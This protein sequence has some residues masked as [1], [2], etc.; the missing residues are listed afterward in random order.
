MTAKRTANSL[1]AHWTFDDAANKRILEPSVAGARSS[2]STS[3]I[4]ARQART[5]QGSG[6]TT[7]AAAA[8]LAPERDSATKDF[9]VLCGMR[10]TNTTSPEKHLFTN[11]RGQPGRCNLTLDASAG[12]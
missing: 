3:C 4:L 10:T 8:S 5:E 6:P 2:R 12:N 9:T 1:V 11:N 7:P